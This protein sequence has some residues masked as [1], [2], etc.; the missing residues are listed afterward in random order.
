MPTLIV[1]IGGVTSNSYE[2][3]AEANTYFEERVPIVPVR[4]ASGQEAALIHATRL[5]DALAQPHKT[6]IP[7]NVAAATIASV[8]NGPDR[9][10][11]RHN[12]SRG[13]A[14]GC[15]TTMVIRSMYLSFQSQR[16]TR[17]S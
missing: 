12:A 15:S 9:P 8:P 4:V 11:R 3:H 17:D 14:W 1:T 5:L 6:F 10:R 16:Q 13:R 2:T 7:V